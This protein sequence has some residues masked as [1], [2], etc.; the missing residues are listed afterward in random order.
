MHIFGDSQLAINQVN[1]DYQIKDE[2]LIP[3]KN[4]IDSLRNYFTFVTFQQIPRA[5]TKAID[6]M[7]ILASIL[8]LEEHESCFQFLAEELHHP[9]YDSLD[10]CVIYAVVGHDSSC[11]ATIFSYL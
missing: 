7:A 10:D 5:E 2:K 3:Y 11:Y 8:Q 6:A 1:N 9:T 4:F